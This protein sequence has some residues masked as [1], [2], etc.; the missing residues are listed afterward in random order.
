M[1]TMKPTN[2][3][4]KEFTEWEYHCQVADA[5]ELD[6]DQYEFGFN[7]QLNQR[8]LKKFNENS[9]RNAYQKAFD[10]HCSRS[11]TEPKGVRDFADWF[12]ENSEEIVDWIFNNKENLSLGEDPSVDFLE[13]RLK[14]SDNG[15]KL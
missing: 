5:L 3:Q 13:Y 7:D 4:I 2:K 9:L 12:E 6:I 10:F 1:N 14:L 11:A 15:P 8:L